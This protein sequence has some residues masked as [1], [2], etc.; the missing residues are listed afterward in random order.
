[1]A[2]ASST[3]KTISVVIPTRHRND[4]LAKCLDC[5]APGTQT[6]AP[7]LYEVIVTDDGSE[8]NA[9]DFIAANYPWARWSDGPH[10]GPAANRN[11]GAR[12]ATG[13]WIVFTDDDC[14]PQPEW[15]SSLYQHMSDPKIDVL[16]GRTYTERENKGPFYQAPVN[17]NGGYLW[18][19]NMAVRQSAFHELNGFDE[20]IPYPHLED[21][22]FRLRVRASG[23]P[24]LF[25]PEAAIF[26]AQ[27]PVRSI[28]SQVKTHESALYLSRKHGLPL[29]FFGL[30]PVV[31]TRI[32]LRL[33]I[34]SA[35]NP[36]EG[37]RFLLTRSLVEGACL[38][39]L[40]PRWKRKYAAST[41]PRVGGAA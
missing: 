31:Y 25:V 35:R 27:R 12:Q 37:L 24:M 6:L 39:G 11:N 23:R 22:D 20:K 33:A 9:R 30:H 40:L 34:R 26:H 8:T 18:S 3:P 17:E 28:L 16:E 13:E 32:Q 41:S 10:R 5:L 29:K 14:E 36:V 7:E 1:M 21:V 19:C 15:L 4:L 2:T 38:I